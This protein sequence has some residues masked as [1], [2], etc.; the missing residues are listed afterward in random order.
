MGVVMEEALLAYAAGRIDALEGNRDEAK[1]AD[2]VTGV[3]YRRGFLDGRLDVFRM[4][5]GVRD[6]L[7]EYD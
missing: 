6:L 2:P 7:R 4:L 3:D 1:A 5:A